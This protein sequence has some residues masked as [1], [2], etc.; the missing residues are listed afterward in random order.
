MP[1]KIVKYNGKTATYLPCTSPTEL[2]EVGREYEVE[3]E[4]DKGFQTDYIL[5]GVH[6]RFNSVWFDTV[7]AEGSPNNAIGNTYLAIG[8]SE[9][10]VGQRYFC[11]RI[12]IVEK[13]AP[14]LVSVTTT[15]VESVEEQDSNI[16]RVTTKNSVYIVQVG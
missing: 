5:K 6:G 10:I 15:T 16:Y 12:E 8:T 4:E 1:K 9:P 13:N 14:Q 11:L 7:R 3:H 2:L